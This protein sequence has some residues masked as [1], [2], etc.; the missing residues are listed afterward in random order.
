MRPRFVFV[1]IQSGAGDAAVEQGANQRFLLDEAKARYRAA[2]DR[3]VAAL[4]HVAAGD[5]PATAL[6]KELRSAGNVEALASGELRV[7]SRVY[8]PLKVD[9]QKALRAGSVLADV[10]ETV[11]HDLTCGPDDVL[12]FE[13]RA[14]NSRIDPKHLPA[15]IMLYRNFIRLVFLGP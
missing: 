14:H 9:P 2:R 11:V 12:R 8:I 15:Q 7:L 1:N 6:L 4:E 10:G 3:A 5:V 13:R